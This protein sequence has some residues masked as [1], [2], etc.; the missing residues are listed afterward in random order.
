MSRPR[1]GALQGGGACAAVRRGC[2]VAAM[3]HPAPMPPASL[4]PAT[5]DDLPAITRLIGRAF[6]P[7]RALIGRDPA[8]IKADHAAHVARGEVEVLQAEAG[9]IAVLIHYADGADWH[10]D[11][12]AV[13]PAHAGAGHGKRLIAHTE[14]R[15]RAAGCARITLYTNEKMRANRVMYPRLGYAETGRSITDGF[16]RI[17]YAKPL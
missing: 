3:T 16:A 14:A 17:H 15:A 7:Y 9:L 12:V 2:L 1:S 8:P 13:D 6:G 10:L 11:T 5:P 4:R